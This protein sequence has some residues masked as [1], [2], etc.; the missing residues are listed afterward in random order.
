MDLT[1]PLADLVGPNL[2]RLL[3]RL[4]LL[5]EGVTTRQ[6]ARLSGVPHS[7]AVRAL[8]DLEEIGLV[9][10]RDIG[11]AAVHTLNREHVLWPGIDLLLKAPSGIEQVVAQSV[12]ETG[13]TAAV[14]GSAARGDGG[15]GSDIDIVVVWDP[16]VTA[17]RREET[18]QSMRDRVRAS[19]GNTVDVIDLDL[20]DLQRMT[21]AH[22]P[23][24]ESWS[25]EARTVIGIDLKTRIAD[26]AR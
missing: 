10:R 1:L 4:S 3:R 7:S 13:A 11:T 20:E 2:A 12:E 19:T 6:L 25:D 14:Y 16:P 18:L 15:R 26:A 5:S 24:L 21:A 22:D 8:A 23:L 9:T 17:D